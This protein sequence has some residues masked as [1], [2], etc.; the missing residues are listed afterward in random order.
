MAEARCGNTD[1][2][3]SAGP[4]E[5]PSAEV[6]H[7]AD[8]ATDNFV[9]HDAEQ[10]RFGGAQTYEA[11]FERVIEPANAATDAIIAEKLSGGFDAAGGAQLGEHLVHIPRCL[12]NRI[13]RFVGAI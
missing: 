12:L 3:G 8:R 9:S 5:L 6:H 13:R 11:A 2:L 1:V 4:G 7:L 10:P